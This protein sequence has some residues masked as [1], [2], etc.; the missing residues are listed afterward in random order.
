MMDKERKE[1]KERIA[2]RMSALQSAS[3]S[4]SEAFKELEAL[5]YRQTTA[6]EAEETIKI[7][8]EE[9]VNAI[10]AYKNLTV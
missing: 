2:K 8:I 6:E 1:R 7:Q 5:F 3:Q 4:I 10:T 9:A